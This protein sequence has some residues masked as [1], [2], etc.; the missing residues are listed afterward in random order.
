MEDDPDQGILGFIK[1]LFKRRS[2]PDNSSELAEE[3]HDLMDRGQAK[4][5]IS[6]EESHM[7][8]GVLD[9]KETKANSI[10]VPRTEISSSSAD[11]TIGEI[12]QLVT[13]CG[14]TR[15]PIHRGNID[16]I[17]GI[18]HAKDLLRLLGEN[19]DAKIP[20]DI[21]RKPYFVPGT[22][23]VSELLRDLKA[24]QTHMAVVTD[25]YGGTAGIITIEDIL[26]EIVG[27]IMDEHDSE[28]QLLTV[29]EGGSLLVD[30]RL[31]VE[32]LEEKINKDLPKGD[33]ESVG[34][35]IIHI[36]GRIPEVDETI[37]FEDLEITVRKADRRKIDKLLITPKVQPGHS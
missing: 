9:L 5:F 11:S 32:K 18:L 26:E 24:K 7:V 25:E 13:D 19:P 1:S 12:I 3:I 22:A 33:F 27:E 21:L 14:H 29:T 34:G 31:G 23:Q 15:I 20:D 30:A 10:M 6:D 28:E 8:Y 35:F 2:H 4:G 36:L 17:I 16:N 37:S